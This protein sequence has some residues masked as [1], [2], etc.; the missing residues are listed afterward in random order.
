VRLTLKVV[1]AAGI[2]KAVRL[3]FARLKKLFP[4]VAESSRNGKSFQKLFLWAN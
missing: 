1:A 3:L 4:L 2:K